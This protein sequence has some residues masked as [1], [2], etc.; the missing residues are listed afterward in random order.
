MTTPITERKPTVG[1]RWKQSFVTPKGKLQKRVIEI[2]AAP[3]LS[4]PI[5]YRIVKN[6]A[7]PHRKGKTASIRVADLHA[8]YEAV[9]A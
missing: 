1:S 3:T 5:G 2:I 9:S 8:K 7:H 4:S 6:D